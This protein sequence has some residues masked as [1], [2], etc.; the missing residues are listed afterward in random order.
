[1]HLAR[2]RQ[3]ELVV[4]RKGESVTDTSPSLP[5]VFGVGGVGALVVLAGAA[6]LVSLRDSTYARGLRNLGGV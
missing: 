3:G 5:L 6:A 4:T 2:Y 1:M